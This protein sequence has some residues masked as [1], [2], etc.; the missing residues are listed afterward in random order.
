MRS[1]LA[2][3]GTAGGTSLNYHIE[4]TPERWL[5]SSLGTNF[6]RHELAEQFTALAREM[7]RRHKSRRAP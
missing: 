1:E 4:M 7:E 5:P 6:M 2:V 3:Q